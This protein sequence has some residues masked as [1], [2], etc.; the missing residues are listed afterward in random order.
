[1]PDAAG[2]IRRDNVAIGGENVTTAIEGLEALQRETFVPR[3]F[4]LT[5]FER[6]KRVLC[7]QPRAHIPFAEK[8]ADISCW[9]GLRR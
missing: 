9:K 8:L 1:V 5:I 2:D 7:P 4:P 3:D 6:L